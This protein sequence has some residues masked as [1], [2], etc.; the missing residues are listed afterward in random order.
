MS[1][2]KNNL[3]IST[4]YVHDASRPHS[5][6]YCFLFLTSAT[7]RSKSESEKQ[8]HT[9]K[10]RSRLSKNMSEILESSS[11]NPTRNKILEYPKGD[12]LPKL[13]SDVDYVLGD[14]FVYVIEELVRG[15]RVV[16]VER[17][18][19][20]LRTSKEFSEKDKIIIIQRKGKDSYY[21][22][23]GKSENKY[24]FTTNDDI[25]NLIETFH[26]DRSQS[27]NKPVSNK[28][29]FTDFDS[30][31]HNTQEQ[32]YII[33]EE[34]IIFDPTEQD[35]TVRYTNQ[36]NRLIFSKQEE[37]LYLQ[38]LLVSSP[39]PENEKATGYTLQP[40]LNKIVETR[41]G[42][43]LY[44]NPTKVATTE[45]HLE[46]WNEYID[47]YNDFKKAF[48]NQAYIKPDFYQQDSETANK[49][50]YE[51]NIIRNSFNN[52]F[53]MWNTEF[54]NTVDADM[55]DCESLQA[56]DREGI[57][58]KHNIK[59]PSSSSRIKQCEILLSYNFLEDTI[60]NHLLNKSASEIRAIAQKHSVTGL[61]K[62]GSK[63]A[64]SNFLIKNHTSIF[65]DIFT[66]S[67]LKDIVK[68]HNLPIIT[69]DFDELFDKL[70]AT[71]LVE[72]AFRRPKHVGSRCGGY[73]DPVTAI[74]A[75][76]NDPIP[77]SA[78]KRYLQIFRQAD[79]DGG[80]ITN[81]FY[82]QGNKD[83]SEFKVFD[84]ANYINI[85]NNIE[86][87]LPVK[88]SVY[89]HSAFPAI[90]EGTIEPL[91]D[92]SLV[93]T[94]LKIKTGNGI[95]YYNLT[96]IHDNN[97][98]VY[99]EFYEGY[100]YL[101]R[102]LDKN[103]FFYTQ[104]Y[105]YEDMLRFVSL[106]LKEYTLLFD[107]TID[108]FKNYQ[109]TMKLFDNDILDALQDDLDILNERITPVKKQ[110]ITHA[111]PS[112]T[113]IT[114]KE[115]RYDFLRFND[116]NISDTHKMFLLQQLE[117]YKMIR[118]IQLDRMGNHSIQTLDT[119]KPRDSNQQDEPK[120][121]YQVEYNFETFDDVKNHKQLVR[122]DIEH[123]TDVDISLRRRGVERYLESKDDVARK[124]NAYI[125]SISSF[126]SAVHN[127]MPFDT[128]MYYEKAHGELEGVEENYDTRWM[129]INTNPNL[130]HAP[131][132]DDEATTT[133]N[134]DA[135]NNLIA[136][137]G[138]KI[139]DN[140][141][142]YIRRSS[143]MM[144]RIFIR[145]QQQK[146]R[147]SLSNNA[148][149]ALFVSFSRMI[150]YAGFVTLFAQ[151]RYDM[152]SVFK[153]CSN[154]FSLGGFP[155]DNNKSDKSF[156]AYISCILFAQLKRKNKYAQSEKVVQSYV[157]SAIR[158]VFQQNPIIKGMFDRL[159]KERSEK[160]NK[161]GDTSS[162]VLQ[163]FKPYYS[164]N[165]VTER[166]KNGL[167]SNLIPINTNFVFHQIYEKKVKDVNRNDA[168]LLQLLCPKKADKTK[169]AILDASGVTNFVMIPKANNNMENDII[170]ENTLDNRISDL[171]ES[172]DDAF[173]RTNQVRTSE[174]SKV[175]IEQSSPEYKDSHQY[176]HVLDPNGVYRK[177]LSRYEPMNKYAPVF[178]THYT[179]HSTNTLITILRMYESLKSVLETMVQD[180][181]EN[182]FV[183]LNVSENVSLENEVRIV[184][185]EFREHLDDIVNKYNA[186]HVDPEVLKSRSEIL[187]EEDKQKKLDKY[188]SLTDDQMMIM[189][190]LEETFGSEAAKKM[191]DESLNNEN[192][193]T[194][195]DIEAEEMDERAED[196][197]YED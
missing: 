74:L 18:T 110:K 11:T 87:F 183:F 140:E 145:A 49:K 191:L 37:M 169:Y 90:V 60:G 151:Y 80:V 13:F 109:S 181:T 81:G 34:D 189:R 55:S 154:V 46:D 190:E 63:S 166:I 164:S 138:V 103:I 129:F 111:S 57:F 96:N 82:Y 65:K 86:K 4:L 24:E 171:I 93:G 178:R 85:L 133:E 152:L 91:N 135:L 79:I 73:D 114:K 167:K 174:F 83:V 142:D 99:P 35:I 188:S 122:K 66:L 146:N 143:D 105:P 22:V 148:D 97:F 78:S 98:Y 165:R 95:L 77:L 192:E 67:V 176:Y 52:S 58:K 187:R 160:D 131:I 44:M 108:S 62:S 27:V 112:Q 26:I 179:K 51:E 94:L 102:D 61:P 127:K 71:N 53:V 5:I 47:E 149:M 25:I 170:D 126:F 43:T 168:N 84:V 64:I 1:L 180:E 124:Y 134:N 41:A 6:E 54:E 132:V 144:I 100:R 101:K 14:E 193:P 173:F 115:S 150:S 10:L 29:D 106:S 197:D 70:R 48:M 21:P 9:E 8:K 130:F 69:D 139:T 172:F 32:T 125:E 153:G 17:E 92:D 159:A 141:K 89:Y 157:E 19:F 128:E 12:R 31:T 75:T 161:K 156:V 119:V 104:Q 42:A 16:F 40:L 72:F 137:A 20:V 59:M 163:Y 155:M 195:D 117:Y 116:E 107:V 28:P 36:Q 15:Y 113:N 30:T 2:L 3:N 186:Q 56:S 182:I 184:V 120:R 185:R 136:V 123:N 158:I 38:N 194:E 118:D 88:C 50:V 147:Q 23:F 177:I 162:L 68:K 76:P 7:F 175:F 33:E 39:Y 196:D 45:R 121:N